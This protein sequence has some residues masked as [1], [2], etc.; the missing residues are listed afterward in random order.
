MSLVGEAEI[1]IKANASAFE[2]E[3]KSQTSSGFSSLGTEADKASKD[4]TKALE[5]GT[6]KMA[7]VMEGFGS[8]AK[9][10]LAGLG[11]PEALLTGPG[12]A[13]AAGAAVAAVSIK[14]AMDMQKADVAIANSE[15]I[16]VKAA[17]NVGNAML[18]TA[19]KTEFSGQE[20]AKAFSQVA[21]QL[22]SAEGGSLSTAKS[23]GFMNTA[24]DLATAKGIDLNT[25]TSTLATTMQAFKIPVAQAADASNI[26]FNTSNILGMGVDQVGMQMD[27]LK[28][29]LGATAPPM[30]DLAGLMVDLTNQGITGRA[31]LT[32]VNG[33][34]T[35]LA[36]TL[37]QSTTTTR[38]AVDTL[39]QYGLSATTANGQLTPMS[40][41]I[42]K[43]GP[44]FAT[45]TQAQQLATATNIFGASAAKG[46]VAVID[47]GTRAYT[48][49]TDAVT[50]HNAVQDAAAAKSHTLSVEFDTMKA[51]AMDFATM[52]GQEL[53]P[54]L[55]EVMSVVSELIPIIG[56]ALKAA[57]MII[58]PVV[59]TVVDSL[60]IAIQTLKDLGTFVKDIFTGDWSGA[61]KAVT[62]VFDD[63]VKLIENGIMFI[64]N[65][66][67]QLPG[68]IGNIM[69]S[70]VDAIETPFV[71]AF[72]FV[73]KM[74]N[75]TLG[76]LPSWLGGGHM[77]S[78][79]TTFAG[80]AAAASQSAAM[81]GVSGKSTAEHRGT[82]STVAAITSHASTIAKHVVDAYVAPVVAA[83]KTHAAHAAHHT[84]T[85]HTVVHHT[86]VHGATKGYASVAG[87]NSGQ[88][89]GIMV[90]GVEVSG[91]VYDAAIGAAYGK[92]T[93]NVAAAM[94]PKTPPTININAG[95]VVIHPAPGNDAHSLLATQNM[96]NEM[97]KELT[98]EL[99]SGVTS[100][101]TAS[102]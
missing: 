48:S 63:A 49:S 54:I 9:S 17:T 55:S 68:Q 75:D 3:L 24:M 47:A 32:V 37:G 36:N 101:S 22:K 13:V 5:S 70:V 8:K 97:L 12:I 86:G 60:K 33:A 30:K 64:P 18:A 10:S 34:A 45:M 53:M 15:G 11:V 57:F 21:G 80:A 26:L 67:G 73:I 91:A 92:Q 2:A 66:I 27:K 71:A 52:L 81:A 44:K 89:G 56:T 83:A 82:A 62:A 14:M 93:S 76:K 85:H 74:Y 100:L 58:G 72:N 96:I 41:I 87:S 28:A 29:R 16:S 4:A 46:M 51:A 1:I 88:A 59:K 42:E 25:A 65:L 31:S 43:L 40:T 95:A 23:M 35:A 38:L 20:Q 102:A 61:W 77:G 6:G 98:T 39:K 99:Q 69:R 50:R 84:T 90:N 94:Q 19:G 78:L 79:H 7:G